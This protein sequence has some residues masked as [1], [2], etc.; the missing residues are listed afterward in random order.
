[1]QFKITSFLHAIVAIYQRISTI[2]LAGMATEGQTKPTVKKV[3]MITNINN[4]PATF[5]LP[6]I[7]DRVLYLKGFLQTTLKTNSLNN[8]FMVY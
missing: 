8:M 5:L 4:I 6:H 2:E 7:I 3:N 1:M